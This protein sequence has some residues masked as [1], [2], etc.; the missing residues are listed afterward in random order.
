MRDK[1]K[2]QIND[3]NMYAATNVICQVFGNIFGTY[4]LNRM[5][6]VPEIIIGVFGYFSAMIEY[7]V[8]GLATQPWQLYLGQFLQYRTFHRVR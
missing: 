7:I 8:C 1:F 5:L 3:Y 2:W 6:Q 4:V